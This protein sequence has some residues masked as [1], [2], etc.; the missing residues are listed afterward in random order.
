MN[1]MYL[2]FPRP[3]RKRLYLISQIMLFIS[4]PS[5]FKD[6]QAYEY[7]IRLVST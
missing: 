3:G 1:S 5:F 6:N 2:Q 4:N 7:V